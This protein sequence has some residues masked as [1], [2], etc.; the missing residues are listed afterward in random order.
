MGNDLRDSISKGK[1]HAVSLSNRP[2][3]YRLL[4]YGLIVRYLKLS[5]S[6]EDRLIS[7]WESDGKLRCSDDRAV[8]C[9]PARL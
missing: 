9:P 1:S 8:D 2:S 7:K 5:G 4:R 3:M 6:G